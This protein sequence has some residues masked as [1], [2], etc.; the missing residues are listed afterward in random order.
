[1]ASYND[2]TP[3]AEQTEKSPSDFG[4]VFQDSLEPMEVGECA[5]FKASQISYYYYYFCYILLH[6]IITALVTVIEHNMH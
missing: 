5:C 2:N 1:M 3:P 4:E 6:T